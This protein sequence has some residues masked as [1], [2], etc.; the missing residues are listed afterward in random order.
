[1]TK[2]NIFFAC[3]QLHNSQICNIL[4][5]KIKWIVTKEHAADIYYER[6]ANEAVAESNGILRVEA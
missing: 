2:I 6:L 3:M 4:K 1:M 5:K